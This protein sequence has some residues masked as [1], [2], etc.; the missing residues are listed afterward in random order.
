MISHKECSGCRPLFERTL[1]IPC[2]WASV[3]TLPIDEL[4]STATA[5]YRSHPPIRELL[6]LRFVIP[7]TGPHY[8]IQE[9]ADN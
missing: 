3:F 7:S 9:V 2:P 5:G 4:L 8:P 1:T 6:L